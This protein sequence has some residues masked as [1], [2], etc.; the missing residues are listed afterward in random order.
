MG[1]VLSTLL[2][3]S[4]KETKWILKVNKIQREITE[5]ITEFLTSKSIEKE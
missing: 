2:K 3:R 5:L 1:K 4:V